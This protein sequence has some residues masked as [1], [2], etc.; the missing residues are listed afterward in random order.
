VTEGQPGG[1]PEIYEK[2]NQKTGRGA[3]VIF[4]TAAG[5]YTYVTERR[6]DPKV[7]TTGGPVDLRHDRG[8]RAVIDVN[9]TEPGA[10]ILF[11]GV[12]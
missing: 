10:R 12:Q 11:F 3:V 2:I 7:W 4:A 1:S 8:G 9:F 5:R 6:A